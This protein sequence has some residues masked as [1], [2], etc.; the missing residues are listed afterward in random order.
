MSECYQTAKKKETALRYI[1]TAK[2]EAILIEA[3]EK[4]IRLHR[5]KLTK[6]MDYLRA[7]KQRKFLRKIN[8]YEY[9]W[10]G[11]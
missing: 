2:Q 11:D 8:K 7:G 1:E 5:K 6:C 10:I 9:E 3:L 4:E